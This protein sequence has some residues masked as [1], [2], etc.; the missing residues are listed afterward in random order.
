MTV[1]FE[2]D[3]VPRTAAL[4]RKEHVMKKNALRKLSLN[5]DTIRQLA[6][7][8]LEDVQGG[9]INLSQFFPSGCGFSACDAC[10]SNVS[11]CQ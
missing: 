2:T 8:R 9:R 4:I 6:D 10:G 11:G 7:N 5:K 1:S 3:S